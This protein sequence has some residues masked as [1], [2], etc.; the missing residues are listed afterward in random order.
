MEGFNLAA[1]QES[2]RTRMKA[3]DDSHMERLIESKQYD[4]ER[5]NVERMDAQECLLAGRLLIS[6]S[7]MDASSSPVAEANSNANVESSSGGSMNSETMQTKL[8]WNVENKIRLIEERLR[9]CRLETLQVFRQTV[10]ENG[11]LLLNPTVLARDS[12]SGE[13]QVFQAEDKTEAILVISLYSIQRPGLKSQTFE[14]SATRP[15][16]ELRDRL[17]CP[18]ER[19][20]TRL[21]QLGTVPSVTLPTR[22][23]PPTVESCASS[24]YFLIEGLF[25]SDLRDAEATDLS[26]TLRE[27]AASDVARQR[28]LELET[29]QVGLMEKA[30]WIDTPKLRLNRPYSFVHCGRCDH[31]IMIEQVRRF[32]PYDSARP[33]PYLTTKDKT[34]SLPTIREIF[35]LRRRRRKCR[36]CE[37]NRAAWLTVNDRLAPESPCAFCDSCYQSLHYGADG[38]LLYSNYKVYPYYYDY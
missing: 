35:R 15:L 32:H 38:Q 36:I 28:A 7:K 3:V 19:I 1:W 13:R 27:W 34:L 17:M 4:P 14:V 18:T 12:P 21:N 6:S 23:L 33:S 26:L 30:R 29:K 20:I 24:A 5:I 22:D 25:Y 2:W 31:F 37:N 9:K 11:G 16:S 10:E 8:L